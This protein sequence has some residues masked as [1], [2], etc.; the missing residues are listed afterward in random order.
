[1]IGFDVC[2]EVSFEWAWD[3]FV[4]WWG[5]VEV[6]VNNVVMIVVWLV[7]DIMFEEFDVVM[8]VNLCGIFVGSC[9]FG[10]LFKVHGYGWIV[11]LVLLVG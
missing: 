10:K 4:E 2:E 8:V 5:G 9:V 3:V 6:F 7:F 11:N 1:M